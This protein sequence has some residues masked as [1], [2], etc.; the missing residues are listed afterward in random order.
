MYIEGKDL[1]MESEVESELQAIDA[2][3]AELQAKQYRCRRESHRID[4]LLIDLQ[5][6]ETHLR[7]YL[8]SSLQE[9]DQ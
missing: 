7:A 2:Q 9:G 4:Q 6:R 3:R 1:E 8:N 5:D